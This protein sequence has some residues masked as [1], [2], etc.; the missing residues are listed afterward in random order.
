MKRILFVSAGHAFPNGAF[1][2]LKSLQDQEP[3]CVTGLFYSPID[4][5]SMVAA[6]QVP[7]QGPYD[8]L[9][10][11]E[12]KVTEENKAIFVNQCKL[13][14]IRHHIAEYEEAWFKEVLAKESRFSDLLLL[15]GEMYCSNLNDD[16]P[17]TY[18]LEALHSSECPVM[19]VP[20]HYA[21][22]ERLVI[23]YDGTK[24]SLHAIRQFCY[25]LPHYTDLPTEFIYVKDENTKDIPDIENL[26]AFTRLHFSSMN[27]SKLQFK[28]AHYFA[29]WVGEQKHVL[30]VSGSFGRSP[31][32]YLTKRSF[33]EQ[34]IHNHQMPI[35]IAH[36]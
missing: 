4:V 2:F 36:S 8:E 28:A 25:L 24:D 13:H 31:F 3:V 27:F 23:A 20:E 26:K 35:F 18:L 14:Y 9:K 19:V 12:K 6:S 32:S 16:Q 5:G 33:A 11:R 10:E 29:T 7:V 21:E 15:S 30:M 22:P 1:A 17:N 34:V